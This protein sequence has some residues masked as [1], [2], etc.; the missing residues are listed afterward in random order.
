MADSALKWPTA[1]LLI[2]L[3]TGV[4]QGAEDATVAVGPL[5]SDAPGRPGV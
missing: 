4:V 2:L 1:L 5:F 3:I